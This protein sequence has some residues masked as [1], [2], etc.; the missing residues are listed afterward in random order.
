[1]LPSRGVHKIVRGVHK[2]VRGVHNKHK[3]LQMFPR[4]WKH[5]YKTPAWEPKQLLFRT[6][7]SV[8]VH[9]YV[10]SYIQI[11]TQ[12]S[13]LVWVFQNTIKRMTLT[14]SS[15]PCVPILG[16]YSSLLTETATMHHFHPRRSACWSDQRGGGDL[17]WLSDSARCTQQ[18]QDLRIITDYRIVRGVHNKHKYLNMFPRSWKHVYMT[19]AWDPKTVAF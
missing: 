19:P 15:D 11:H 3:Y 4:S 12:R 2:I 17:Y 16:S 14:H 5:V 13:S 7:H 1:M 18:T 10:E 6:T 8:S 9:V